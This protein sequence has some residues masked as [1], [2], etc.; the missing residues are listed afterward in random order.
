MTRCDAIEPLGEFPGFWISSPSQM[1]HLIAN[2]ED[3]EPGSSE[4]EEER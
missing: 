3:P 1:I 4:S 2:D